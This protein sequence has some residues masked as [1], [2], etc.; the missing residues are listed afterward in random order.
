GRVGSVAEV[1]D[2]VIRQIDG[3]PVKVSDVA[4][5]EDGEADLETLAKK[6]ETASVVLSVRKQSGEN[7]V[8]VVNEIKSRLHEVEKSLPQGYRL[9]VV[10][11]NATII[12][13]GV[14]AVKEHLI[15]GAILA[16]I[17][18]LIFLGNVRSTVIAAVAIPTSIIATFGIMWVEGF[19]LNSLTLLALA[20]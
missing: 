5:V 18:V 15:V 8:A 7:T 20:L 3:R 6:N 1:G 19:T 10:R 14:N 13:N 4:R 2:I 9:E 12:E 11:D 17:V 16:A